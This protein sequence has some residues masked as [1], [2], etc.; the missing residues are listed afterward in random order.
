[1]FPLYEHTHVGRL[2][3]ARSDA[4]VGDGGCGGGESVAVQEGGSH[5]ME[6]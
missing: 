6:A 3:C 5:G 1:M 4:G 2:C